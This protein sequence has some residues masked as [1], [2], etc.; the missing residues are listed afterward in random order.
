MGCGSSSEGSAS[1]AAPVNVEVTA[2]KLHSAIRWERVDEV[3]EIIKQSAPTVNVKDESNGNTAIHIAAQ[4]GHL[5]I[6]TMLV[7]AGADVNA[8]NAG[9]QTALHMVR[10]YE[11]EDVATFLTKSGAD[12]EVKNNDGH[13]AKFGLGGERDPNSVTVKIKAFKGATT[14][15]Q[16]LEALKNLKGHE[17]LS[18]KAAMAK[19]GLTKKR[20]NKDV[21]TPAVQ[22]AFSQVLSSMP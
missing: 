7:K 6:V 18:D 1:S 17:G 5:E 20:E 16:L 15:A 22:E 8:Q 12:Q 9:G 2:A 3:K 21:W 13:P 10:T 4:N 14:E 11:L 19:D